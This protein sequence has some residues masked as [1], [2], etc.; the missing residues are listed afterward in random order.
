M[1]ETHA[2]SG[3]GA[4][5]AS[6]PSAD[7]AVTP[8]A[9]GTAI[10]GTSGSVA[11]GANPATAS[12]ANAPAA[13]G[14]QPAAHHGVA[15]TNAVR[16]VGLLVALLVLAAAV[17]LSIAV[18]AKPINVPDVLHG[19]FTPS[20]SDN[21][22]I[23]RDYRVPRTAAAILVGAALGV[24]GALIQALTRNPLADPGILGVNSGA[25]FFVALATA[26]FGVTTIFGYIWFAF[27]GA[28]LVTVA[29][30][31]IG[32][33]GRGPADPVRLTLAG[34]ALSAVLQGVITGMTLLNPT[35]FDQ[36]R[37]WNAGSVVG[38]G[39]DVLAPVVPFLVVGLILAIVVARPLNA[40]ALGEDLAA[41]LGTNITRTRIIVVIAV[42]LMAGGATALA[43]PIGFVGLM[44]PHVAR[45]ITG[46][47]QR[48]ILAYTVL[49]APSLMLLADTLGRVILGGGELPVGIVT[50]FVGAPVLIVLI[51]RKKASGL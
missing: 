6:V 18:G 48:W 30:Y 2:S 32:S 31:L 42:T 7:R 26:V 45:W 12:P 3:T 19:L 33:A 16:M 46:P 47:D 10:P 35:A 34:V 4:K 29:V 13:G 23:V 5:G 21:D 36:M 44:I 8:G 20:G 1:T 28:L 50:A 41:S 38:R 14:T 43:G 40:V 27:G 22:F 25:A 9:D 24:A 17:V 15:H 51:R 11:T 39:F 37:N 49:M